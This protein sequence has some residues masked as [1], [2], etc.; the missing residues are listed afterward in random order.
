M[1]AK[2]LSFTEEFQTLKGGGILELE[3]SPFGYYRVIMSKVRIT[4]GCWSWQVDVWWEADWTRSPSISPNIVNDR[5]E[6]ITLQKISRQSP[7]CQVTR[8]NVIATAVAKSL[9]SC[10][11]LCSPIDGSPPGSPVPWEN[12]SVPCCEVLRKTHSSSVLL[13]PQMQNWSLTQRKHQTDPNWGM[14][15]KTPTTLYFAKMSWLRRTRK[16]W[17]AAS[18][19][20]WWS[21]KDK[22]MQCNRGLD[23]EL[24]FFLNYKVT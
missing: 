4:P 6:I 23:S 7:P 16:D 21:R 8:F 10:P 15:C 3:Q 20:R 14:L 18:D 13:P 9:Q 1:K 19:Q 2:E 11:T 24:E 17:A 22:E 12:S 5:G